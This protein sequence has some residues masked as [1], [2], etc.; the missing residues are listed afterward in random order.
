VARIGDEPRR[1]GSDLKEEVRRLLT[2]L[3]NDLHRLAR[4]RSAGFAGTIGELQQ[5]VD[6]VRADMRRLPD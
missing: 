3:E 5:I 4:N 2:S 1:S 6:D